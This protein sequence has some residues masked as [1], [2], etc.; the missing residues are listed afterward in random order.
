MKLQLDNYT[1]ISFS[2]WGGCDLLV[3]L[4]ACADLLLPVLIE[5]VDDGL[6]GVLWPDVP[7]VTVGQGLLVPAQHHAMEGHG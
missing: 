7:H 6:G 4:G 1:V 3:V 5:G 2:S